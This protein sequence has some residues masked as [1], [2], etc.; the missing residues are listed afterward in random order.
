MALSEPRTLD[1]CFEESRGQDCWV[2]GLPDSRG[3]E[4]C[5]GVG[6]QMLA[7]NPQELSGNGP[8]H[9]EQALN[10]VPSQARGPQKV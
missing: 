5:R 2:E 6:G 7:S 3:E 9:S 10:E 4:E 8:C 1:P